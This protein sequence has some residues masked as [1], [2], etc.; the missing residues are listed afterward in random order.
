MRRCIL[1]Q[2]AARAGVDRRADDSRVGEHAEDQD[3]GPGV[4]RAH[5]L[6]Q[7]DPAQFLALQAKVDHRRV[8]ALAHKGLIGAF[9]IMRFGQLPDPGL[10]QQ[11]AAGRN[12][13]RVVVNEQN[14][15]HPMKVS[16]LATGIPRAFVHHAGSVAN[17]TRGDNAAAPW[18]RLGKMIAHL[19]LR[20]DCPYRAKNIARCEEHGRYLPII[21]FV[22]VS[23]DRLH[24]LAAQGRGRAW[25]RETRNWGTS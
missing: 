1:E 8:R 17:R 5:A 10:A 3:P 14:A 7:A 16:S 19:R 24:V 15:I 20:E 23:S 22:I 21:T 25:K 18:R 4:V 13:D 9:G 6:N 11:P 12:H 2:I